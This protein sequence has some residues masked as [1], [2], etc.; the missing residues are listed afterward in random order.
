MPPRLTRSH[1]RKATASAS[2]PRLHMV[3]SSTH[4]LRCALGSAASTAA[5]H[6][7]RTTR[8]TKTANARPGGMP[9]LGLHG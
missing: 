1:R 3:R 8:N 4:A 5:A 7:N 6:D 2:G 9:E